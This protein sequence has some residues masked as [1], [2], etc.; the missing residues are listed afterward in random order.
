MMTTAGSGHQN[1]PVVPGMNSS[2]TKAT[3]VVRMA[4]VTGVA[5]SRAPLIAAAM[6]SM[7]SCRYS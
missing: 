3:M 6:W 5:T 4:K 1:L 7:P 2:G